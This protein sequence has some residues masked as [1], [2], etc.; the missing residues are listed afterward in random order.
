MSLLTVVGQANA[1]KYD[2]KEVYSGDKYRQSFAIDIDNQGTLI[3]AVRDSFNFP[4]YVEPYLTAETGPFR[5]YCA[6]SDAELTSGE[7]DSSS[8]GCLKLDLARTT[9]SN[10]RVG[11]GASPIYQKIGDYKSFFGTADD[12]TLINIFDFIDDDLGDF[13][14][15]NVEQI[16]ASN[17]NGIK[18]GHG[19]GPYSK[20]SFQQ[21]GEFAAESPVTM[22][23]QDFLSRAV[24]IVDGNVI[25]LMSE[26]TRYGG[27]STVYD[28]SDSNF[29]AGSEAIGLQVGVVTA[30]EEN[31]TGELLPEQVCAWSVFRSSAFYNT[32]PV[33][34]QIDN[35]GNIVSKTQY[36]LVFTPNENQTGSYSSRAIAV[37]DLGIAVGYGH[38][39][40]S[41]SSAA[42][43]DYPLVFQNGTTTE[44]LADHEDYDRGY[45]LDI[46]ENNLIVGNLD[47]Y[48]DSAYNSEFFI[49]DLNSGEL[50][51]PTTF[52][53]TAQST[54][55]GINDEGV[56]V[57]QAEYE[58]TTNQTRRKHGFIYD[59]VK[60][61]FFDL[62]DLTEC[63]SIY[64]IVSTSAINN[65]GQIAA[66][67]LKTVD[68]RDYKG[69]IVIDP[70]TG[71][72][73]Q[74]QVAVAVL[75]SPIDGG[76]LEECA[77]EDEPDYKRKGLSLPVSFTILLSGLIAIRRKFL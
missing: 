3:G 18:V 37:N 44:M 27:Y 70:S 40:Y 48:F 2:I 56:V 31:C 46:N 51:T 4:I 32:R 25:E 30:L 24:A 13:T 43:Q 22:W 61:E 10:N 21:T 36:D 49:Y 57:G 9:T 39:P 75:L 35:S 71:E 76:E 66:T 20:I 19:T 5:S 38:V 69:E 7:F 52:Y 15:S 62:N 59:S 29:I 60:K 55:S 11:Y 74:E 54:A 50:Q 33:V 64:E 26:E 58:V 34:W 12:S 53:S 28:I 23:Q 72:A 1:A 73:Y 42:A 47:T 6:L 67:A 68:T 8:I 45:A 41:D 16:R 63:N 14:N 17:S 77:T 65:A